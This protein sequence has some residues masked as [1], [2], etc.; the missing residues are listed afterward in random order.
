MTTYSI[1]GLEESLF[2]EN[3]WSDSIKEENEREWDEYDEDNEDDE[4][5]E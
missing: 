3:D 1:E 2:D 5:E 4:F